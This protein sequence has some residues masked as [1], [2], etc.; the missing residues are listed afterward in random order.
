[1]VNVKVDFQKCTGDGLCVTVCPIGVF[2]MKK[3]NG[4]EKS[5]PVNQDQC[6][7]CRVCETQCP[8]AAIIVSE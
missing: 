3:K 1:M 7:V 4:S 6:I 8:E 2:E 5:E